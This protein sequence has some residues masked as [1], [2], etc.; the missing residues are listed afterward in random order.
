MTSQPHDLAREFQTT[1]NAYEER[2]VTCG[3]KVIPRCACL[4]CF[5]F[6]K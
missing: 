2:K 4:K 5:H 1:H 6:I 3:T